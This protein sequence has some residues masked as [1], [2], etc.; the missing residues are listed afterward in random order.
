D[1]GEQ[2]ARSTAYLKHAFRS[3][4]EDAVY[5]LVHPLAHLFWCNR[6]AGITAVPAS[7]IEGGIARRLCLAVGEVEN[8]LPMGDLLSG[9]GGWRLRLVRMARLA[10]DHVGD[11][12]L[13][14]RGRVR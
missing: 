4:E 8:L 14:A 1:P 3:P 6:L 13:L 12:T 5:R 2:E 11:E 9:P 10:P 7:D